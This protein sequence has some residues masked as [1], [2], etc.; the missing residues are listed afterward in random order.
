M[1]FP[2]EIGL[3]ISNDIME[4]SF[5]IHFQGG[6]LYGVKDYGPHTKRIT[7]IPKWIKTISC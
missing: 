6:K 5:F 7:H 1:S 4:N 3:G 2:G